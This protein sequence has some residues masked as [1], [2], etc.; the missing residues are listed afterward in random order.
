MAET[1]IFFIYT[2][3]VTWSLVLSFLVSP[4][5]FSSPSPLSLV[6]KGTFCKVVTLKECRRR[7][8]IWVGFTVELASLGCTIIFV[9]GYH[10]PLT[11]P[12]ADQNVFGFWS[13]D[14]WASLV[15]QSLKRL[16]PTWETWV[17]SLGWEDPLEKEMATHSS[18]LAWGIPWTEEPGRLQS[19]GS[20][21]V[22]H[23]WATSL[24]LSCDLRLLNAYSH[25][26]P[27]FRVNSPSLSLC[28]F[29]SVFLCTT[30]RLTVQTW[31]SKTRQKY[32]CFQTL[33]NRHPRTQ[34]PWEKRHIQD[35]HT[36]T[37]PSFLPRGHFQCVVQAGGTQAENSGL[38]GWRDRY[39]EFG[40]T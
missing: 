1:L 39:L 32:Y 14:L 23:D 26:Q 27:I 6:L 31:T 7:R 24:S 28:L 11:P 18:I 12:F 16:P 5:S 22:W 30:M 8:L 9:L 25:W 17:R 15:A 35:E 4:P 10:A 2:F 20:Q 40:D 37:C 33:D 38:A 34:G 13:Y 36:Q 21:R 29:F 3:S 19:T